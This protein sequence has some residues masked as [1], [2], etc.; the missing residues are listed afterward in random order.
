MSIDS[1]FLSWR[2]DHSSFVRFTGES[3]L[4]DRGFRYGQ[5]LFETIALR[6]G[7]LLF[8]EQHYSLLMQAAEKKKFPFFFACRQ[9]LQ[10]FFD[11]INSGKISLKDG[12]LRIYLTAGEGAI[13]SPVLTPGLF[14]TWEQADFP[15]IDQLKEGI[16]LVS[17]QGYYNTHSWGEKSGNYWEHVAVL[18]KAHSKGA[19]EALLVNDAGFFISAAMANLL[20][21]IEEDKGAVLTTPSLAHGARNGV[22]LNWARMF[23]SCEEKNLRLADFPK[24]VAMAITNSRLGVMPVATLDGR[25][26]RQR[27]YAEMLAM[28]YLKEYDL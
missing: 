23:T 15:S 22:I 27:E 1:S 24:I 3:L 13:G 25:P 17:L 14:I 10:N 11:H 20:V 5:H 18:E 21:W 7:R 9:G 4:R 26:L 12:L 8:A 28:N 2:W 16:N 6:H 19:D